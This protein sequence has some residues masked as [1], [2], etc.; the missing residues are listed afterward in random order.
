MAERPVPFEEMLLRAAGTLPMSDRAV[1][2]LIRRLREGRELPIELMMPAMRFPLRVV[3]AVAPDLSVRPEM[4]GK[5]CGLPDLEEQAILEAVHAT[6]MWA[7]EASA[8]VVRRLM[9]AVEIGIRPDAAAA[10][11]RIPTEEQEFL[12]ELL[13]LHARWEAQMILRVWEVRQDR[14]GLRRWLGVARL[15]GSL[16]PKTVRRWSRKAE[17]LDDMPGL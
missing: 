7:G 14:K 9:A 11:M 17:T 2:I 15:V 1:S 5:M 16:R 8:S 13:D 3:G 10:V 4:M 12:F 6:G